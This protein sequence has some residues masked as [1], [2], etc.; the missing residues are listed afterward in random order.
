MA[1]ISV[2][3]VVKGAIILSKSSVV[4]TGIAGAIK[5]FN[6]LIATK[7]VVETAAAC[8][9]IAGVVG[10][11]HTI[12]SIPIE[13]IEGFKKISDGVNNG[14]PSDFMDGVYKLSQVYGSIDDCI[15]DLNELLESDDIQP[16]VKISIEKSVNDMTNLLQNEIEHKAYTLLKEVEEHLKNR[17]KSPLDYSDRIKTIYI[18]HTFDLKDD[19]NELLGR[20]GRI[21]ADISSY[22]QSLSI[23]DFYTY[24]HYLAYCIAGWVLDNLRFTCLKG[25]TQKNLAGDI[26]NQIFAYLKA[27]GL[28]QRDSQ[29]PKFPAKLV[30]MAV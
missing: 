14:S 10:A 29:P 19:Y 18:K 16:E 6:Y 24:D 4:K 1:I 15:S 26:T 5:L 3:S 28:A 13:A 23:G 21:Y 7:G 8:V 9:T 11:A 30:K 25:K 17:G 20:C 22:N 2:L 27:T 12:A